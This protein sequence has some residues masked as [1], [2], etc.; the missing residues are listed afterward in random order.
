MYEMIMSIKGEV[1][2]M[3]CKYPLPEKVGDKRKRPAPTLEQKLWHDKKGVYLPADNFKMMLVGNQNRT[4]A[5]KVLGSRIESGKGTEYL[6]FCKACIWVVGLEDS[7]KVY[8]LPL[9][10]T[11]DDVD[12]RPAIMSKGGRDVVERPVINLPWKM[13]FKIQVLD[14]NCPPE[15]VVRFYEV[16]GLYCGAGVYGPT[17]GRFTIEKWEVVKKKSK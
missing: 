7:Q 16:A 8:Y 6:D 13:K 4:G 9:R 17:F 2:S 12:I 1:P 14:D 11:Y 5:A 10:S 15:K 3:H